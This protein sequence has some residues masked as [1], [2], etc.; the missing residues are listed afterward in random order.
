M[1]AV[2]W[3]TQQEKRT[4]I[5]N[6]VP[7]A[8][9]RK[10]EAQAKRNRRSVAEEVTMLLAHALE[11]DKSLSILELRGLGKERWRSIDAAIHVEGER[12]AWR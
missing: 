2:R 5:V 3:R 6:N 11:P 12:Q 7:D 9:H 4:L 10:L 8:L 1:F